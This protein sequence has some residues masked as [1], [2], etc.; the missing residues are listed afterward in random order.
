MILDPRMP[1]LH[2]SRKER[3]A[4][5]QRSLF[6]SAPHSEELAHLVVQEAFAWTIGLNPFAIDDEL[7]DGSFAHVPDNLFCGPWGGLDIDLAIGDL[8]FIEESF[9]LATVAAPCSGINQYMHPPI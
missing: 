9:G 6:G 5:V 1:R 4:G 7:R 8:V 2:R 3:L